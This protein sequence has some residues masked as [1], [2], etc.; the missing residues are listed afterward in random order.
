MPTA[1][2][3]S[4]LECMPVTVPARGSRTTT[5]IGP[6]TL[7]TPPMEVRHAVVP[8]GGRGTRM[9]PVT[10]AVPKELLPL[11]VT[12][13]IDL[14]L[15]ELA[16]A[17]LTEVVVVGAPDK[18]ALRDYLGD[19][20]HVIDQPQPRG[21]GDAVLC[22]AEVVGDRPFAV[23]LPDA[24]VAH[25]VLPTLLERALDGAVALE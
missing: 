5:A 14:V 24:L 8:A 17:G 21:L 25:H 12:P 13:L 20:V 7:H 16:A 4:P 2:G 1:R 19:R 10:R 11:G 18:P 15:D 22:A 9:E 6:R 3:R 23:A